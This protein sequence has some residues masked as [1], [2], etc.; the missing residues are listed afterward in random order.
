MTSTPTYSRRP[1]SRVRAGEPKVVSVVLAWGLAAWLAQVSSGEAVETAT[2][3]GATEAG[4]STVAFTR[5]STIALAQPATTSPERDLDDAQHAEELAR[6]ALLFG[7]SVAPPPPSLKGEEENSEEAREAALF[8]AP[9]EEPVRAPAQAPGVG[10]LDR[11]R[12]ELEARDDRLSIGGRLLLQ[13]QTNGLLD[14]PAEE[15]GISAP[16][17]L[18]VYLDA[19]PSERVRA[20]AQGRIQTDFTVESSQDAAVAGTSTDLFGFGISGTNAI[21]D[22]L[23]VKFDIAQRVYVTAGQQRLRWGSSRF[24]NPTDFV[25]R[26]RLNPVA[27]F[28]QRIGIGLLKFHLPLED[29]GVNLYAIVDFEDA[30]RLDR[31]A[32]AFRAEWVVGTA[33]LASSFAYQRERGLRAGLD[34]SAGVGRFELRSEV[35]LA[36]GDR[37]V[38][39]EGDFSS[40]PLVTPDA[41]DR[42]DELLIQ[43]TFGGDTSFRLNEDNDTLVLGFEYFFNDAGYADRELYPYLILSSFSPEALRVL[44]ADLPEDRPLPGFA[45]FTISRH[46]VGL[47]ALLAAPGSW[48]DTSF[49]FSGLL[50]PGRSTSGLLRVDVSQSVLTFLSLR[51]FAGVFFGGRGAF[52]PLLQ[53]DSFQLVAGANPLPGVVP[54]L[55]AA[56]LPVEGFEPLFNLGTA[57]TLDF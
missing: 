30:N 47:Y 16:S 56:F 39:F 21:L 26:Q 7:G 36:Y 40:P 48:D 55:D 1:G 46:Y 12:G 57:I 37:A 53:D 28:D 49:V 42:E 9:L 3:A 27:L 18:E 35:A 5:S 20:F 24:F 52:K 32:G 17:F 22:Q 38:F 2:T 54:L 51:F 19:R 4:S 43:A 23:W 8:G 15:V 14:Q 41:L 34:V 29:A 6:E 50:D 45:P 31:L 44:G 11:M 25:N 10:L 13:L 33:E